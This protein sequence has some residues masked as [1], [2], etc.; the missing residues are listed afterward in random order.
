MIAYFQFRAGLGGHFFL[1]TL[2]WRYG[3][4]PRPIANSYW[5]EY[6]FPITLWEDPNFKR[7]PWDNDHGEKW[8][9]W[10]TGEITE[11]TDEPL[12]KHFQRPSVRR[13]IANVKKDGFLLEHGLYP[14]FT[15]TFQEE[16][17]QECATFSISSRDINVA[18]FA[19]AIRDVKSDCKNYFGIRET[20]PEAM[21]IREQEVWVDNGPSISEM[22]QPYSYNED[23]DRYL[24]KQCELEKE[25]CDFYLDYEKLCNGSKEPWQ[26]IDEY[27][28]RDS[29]VLHNEVARHCQA[30]H[31]RNL[32]IYKFKVDRVPIM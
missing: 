7:I 27:Y 28:K 25:H 18:R 21:K 3:F 13:E 19:R 26:M 1:R 9:D 32:E 4:S 16:F 14:K 17:G 5:N 12:R 10:E 31:L 20:T 15:K 11:Y 2:L 29:L 6:H 8:Y 22:V 30:Y 24:L 23:Q